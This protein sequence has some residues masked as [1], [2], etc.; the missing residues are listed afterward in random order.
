[1]KNVYIFK[2]KDSV[3][4]QKFENLQRNEEFILTLDEIK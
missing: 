4:I 3:R 2:D 1:M